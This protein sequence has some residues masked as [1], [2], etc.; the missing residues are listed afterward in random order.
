M[1]EYLRIKR[2]S[3]KACE[4]ID[5]GAPK[6]GG[7]IM[8]VSFQEACEGLKQEPEKVRNNIK[9]IIREVVCMKT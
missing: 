5:N 4:W 1:K 8:H 6:R 7:R 2:R 3:E 9:N